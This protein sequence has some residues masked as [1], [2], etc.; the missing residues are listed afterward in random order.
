MK[1]L[2]LT[3]ILISPLMAEEKE[4]AYFTPEQLEQMTPE[5]C[6]GMVEIPAG[7]FTF[8]DT[9][10][11]KNTKKLSRTLRAR[12]KPVRTAHTEAFLIDKCEATWQQLLATLLM[13]KS[14][15]P[16]EM[17]SEK[18]NK[19]FDQ[20]AHSWPRAYAETFCKYL[21]KRLPTEEEWEKA[22]R[23]GT[24]TDYYWGD[25]Y[26]DLGAYE[27][28]PQKY[29]LRMNTGPVAQK[30]PN[31]YGL[32]DMLG[33]VPEMTSGDCWKGGSVSH[34][35]AYFSTVGRCITPID[36]LGTSFGWRCV[37]DVVAS[38]SSAKA[39]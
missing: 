22:A 37:K 2:A 20:P 5:R 15:P 3:L 1:I 9:Y 31:P 38:T 6:R 32:Y 14:Q 24:S 11:E 27:Q 7:P 4:P 16:D 12:A 18:Q 26:E 34:W 17:N 25:D 29:A 28:K 13:G 35:G 36:S 30:A 8:G 19:Y 10:A 21:G 33:N 39:E 23:G